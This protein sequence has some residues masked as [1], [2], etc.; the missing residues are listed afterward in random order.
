M[1]NKAIVVLIIL[2]ALP[3]AILP[4]RPDFAPD[5][6]RTDLAG[7]PGAM[8]FIMGWFALLTLVSWLPLVGDGRP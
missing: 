8:W 6:F 4:A 5:C 3:A 2:L 7:V 1:R